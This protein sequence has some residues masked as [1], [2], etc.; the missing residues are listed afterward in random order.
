MT[1]NSRE[2]VKVIKCV[3]VTSNDCAFNA[4]FILESEI[5]RFHIS[6]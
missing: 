6:D 3:H 2:Q 1:V 5:Y 4:G